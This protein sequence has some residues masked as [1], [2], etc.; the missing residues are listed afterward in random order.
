[1]LAEPPAGTPAGTTGTT[2]NV[3]E[4]DWGA[5]LTPTDP[6]ND[7]A[8]YFAGLD[9]RSDSSLEYLR[10]TIEWQQHQYRM[11]NLWNTHTNRRAREIDEWTRRELRDL[12]HRAV[13]FY[14]FGGPD[15][16]YAHAYFP[17][18]SRYILVGL[19]PIN[20]VPPLTTIAGTEII[21][22]LNGLYESVDDALTYGYFQT[23]EMRTDLKRT[24]FSGVL[25]VLYTFLALTGNRIELIEPIGLDASGNRYVRSGGSHAAPG[26]RIV[27]RSALGG[28]KELYYFQ[29]DLSDGNLRSDRR[30]LAFV[31]SGGSPVTYLKSASY[32]LHGS[33]FSVMRDFILRDSHAIVQ[34]P[35]GIPF[36]YFAPPWQVYLYGNYQGPI[37]LFSEHYQRDLAAAFQGGQYP[38][39]PLNFGAGYNLNK[40][41]SSLLVARR[42]R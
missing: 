13:V 1:M 14:P 32:L 34:D 5:P 15:F 42:M 30:L 16:L 4:P 27:F 10:H 24:R 11:R 26:V 18:A 31:R 22:V 20:T 33:R 38:I 6:L 29:E 19:E 21:T 40:G 41:W 37:D 35:S 2:G 36:R 23:K 17:N 9:G 25:P 7:S 3:P 28:R 39:G 12:Q 8:R